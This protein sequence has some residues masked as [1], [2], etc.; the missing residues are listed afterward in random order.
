M[1]I[2][3]MR[4]SYIL[5]KA[6]NL[7]SCGICHPKPFSVFDHADPLIVPVINFSTAPYF[8]VSSDVTTE[9]PIA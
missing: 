5:A 2:S 6:G 4:I 1:D 3:L 8:S 7:S 9:F